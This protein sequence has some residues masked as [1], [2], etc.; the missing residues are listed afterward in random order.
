M[1]TRGP[2]MNLRKFNAINILANK[3]VKISMSLSNLKTPSNLMRPPDGRSVS[4][5]GF[6]EFEFMVSH[7]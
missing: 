3:Q 1:P 5:V 4:L 6:F 7:I 2:R